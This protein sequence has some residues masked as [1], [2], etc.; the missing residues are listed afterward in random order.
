MDHTDHVTRAIP[1]AAGE[2]EESIM[3]VLGRYDTELQMFTETPRDPGRAHL[4]F[5]RWLAERGQL[6][7][8]TAG[9]PGGEYVSDEDDLDARGWA[10]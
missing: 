1:A 6:E 4:A 10:A 8:A 5:L 2:C 9:A 3:K 7:H